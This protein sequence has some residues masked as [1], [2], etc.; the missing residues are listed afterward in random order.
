MPEKEYWQIDSAKLAQDLDLTG[1]AKTEE[2]VKMPVEPV[3]QKKGRKPFSP[4]IRL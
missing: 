1:T 3:L 2:D 4:L